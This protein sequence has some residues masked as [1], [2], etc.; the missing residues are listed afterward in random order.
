MIISEVLEVGLASHGVGHSLFGRLDS[1]LIGEHFVD[2]PGVVSRRYHWFVWSGDAASP[3]RFPVHVA[4]EWV[5][6]DVRGVIRARAESFGL[7]AIQQR[8]E[9]ALG[10]SAEVLLHGDRH[11]HD[12]I[13]HLLS[14]LLVV[15]RPP[16]QHLI[17]EG[18]QTPPVCCLPVADSLD[19]LWGEVLR[20]SAV[21]VGASPS[22]V[23][24]QALLGQAEIGD[25]HVALVVEKH[26]FRLQVSVNDA[27]LVQ[28]A[29]SFHQLSCVEAGAS[30]AELLVLPQVVEKLS[31]VQEVHH[32]VELGRRLK[33]VVKLHDEWTVYLFQD[34][35]LGL[36]L[37]E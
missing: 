23:R 27:V 21:R 2:V 18:A 15:R 37:D 28:T 16:T 32:E 12:V 34:V 19:N 36:R 3:Y 11:V 1:L 31:S 17:D 30:L 13:H 20:R 10:F 8:S 33:G 26:V 5:A 24:L 6:H 14:I 9:Q 29:K 25:F 7:V 22:L 35:T 4:E